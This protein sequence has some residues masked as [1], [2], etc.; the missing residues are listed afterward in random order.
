MK[1]VTAFVAGLGRALDELVP[2]VE[3]TLRYRFDEK[4]LT[5]CLSL[6][7]RG[8]TLAVIEQAFLHDD[9]PDGGVAD[10]VARDYL[11]RKVALLRDQAV[12]VLVPSP[13]VRKGPPSP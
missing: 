3:M 6:Q 11:R 9:L 13:L 4:T 12:E 1:T 2:G 7:S 5:V 10:A 8:L